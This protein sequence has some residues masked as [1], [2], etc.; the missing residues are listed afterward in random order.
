MTRARGRGRGRG[1]GNSLES[2]DDTEVSF[3]SRRTCCQ[4]SPSEEILGISADDTGANSIMRSSCC[5][6]R[7]QALEIEELVKEL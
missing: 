7:F 5:L 4:E 1:R 3:A 2:P 6:L